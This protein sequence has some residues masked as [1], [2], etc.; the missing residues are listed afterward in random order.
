MT[1]LLALLHG[2]FGEKLGVH[3]AVLRR[4][5]GV[6]RTAQ[7]LYRR[8]NVVTDKM[9]LGRLLVE[10]RVDLPNDAALRAWGSRPYVEYYYASDLR[11]NIA[12][13]LMDPKLSTGFY[14][15]PH[16]KLDSAGRT[17]LHQLKSIRGSPCSAYHADREARLGSPQRA[18]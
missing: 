17:G 15:D 7:T 9:G 18:A 4:G 3:S 13:K 10:G 6:P 12:V 16:Y 8:A 11:K 14:F 1:A 5:G 2:I